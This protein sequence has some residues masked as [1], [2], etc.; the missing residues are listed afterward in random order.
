MKK[1]FTCP[2]IYAYIY[3]YLYNVLV[4]L[5][6]SLGFQAA[7]GNFSVPLYENEGF[8]ITVTLALSGMS[9]QVRSNW[10]V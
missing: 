1:Y 6:L 2:N 4:V 3:M 10:P 8:K 9:S 5:V 7:L